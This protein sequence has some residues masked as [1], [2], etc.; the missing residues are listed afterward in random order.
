VV[1]LHFYLDLPLTDAAA[2]LDIP[3]GTAKSRLHRALAA[4][5]AGVGSDANRQVGERAAS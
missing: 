4:M 2:I 3:L 1:V 5:R